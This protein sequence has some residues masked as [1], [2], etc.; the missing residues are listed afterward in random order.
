MM[1]PTDFVVADKFGLPTGRVL[2][3]G[4][5]RTLEEYWEDG[6]PKVE[7][8]VDGRLGEWLRLI[9]TIQRKEKVSGHVG[10]I[11]VYHGKFLIALAH[12]VGVG[13]KAT[14]I[15]VFDD[16]SKNIDGSGAGSLQRCQENIRKYGAAEVDY[17]F[18]QADS[19]A[20]TQTDKLR[21]ME[22]RGPFRLFSVDGC[23]TTEHTVNDLLTAQ[24]LLSPGGVVILDDF[25][26][27]HWPGV[28]EAAHL[29]Y[30]RSTPR[31]KPFLFYCHKLF[32]VGVGWHAAFFQACLA[33]SRGRAD[34]KVASIFGA[35]TVAIYP[36]LEK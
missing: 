11:G 3:E 18:V 14:A 33:Y 23:H 5:M 2:E 36:V 26:N 22:Q 13:G 21:L 12:L 16:Q 32:F 1:A 8:W 6:F 28:T 24:E 17:S 34:M 20:L 31:I 4:V 19:I 30:S 15:D 10:E 7:G 27:P 29:F 35:N 25:M 9:D